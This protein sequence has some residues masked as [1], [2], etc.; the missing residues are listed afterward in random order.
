MKSGLPILC[1]TAVGLM[2]SLSGDLGRAVSTPFSSDVDA[3]VLMFCVSSSRLLL[4]I[5]SVIACC[6]APLVVSMVVPASSALVADSAVPLASLR[7]VNGIDAFGS[8]G[9]VGGVGISV[10]TSGL[11]DAGDVLSAFLSSV[12]PFT[13]SSRLFSRRGSIG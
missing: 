4:P 11:V 7:E 3:S 6:I 12:L 8:G 2:F 5:S 13:S 1:F 10:F 9:G